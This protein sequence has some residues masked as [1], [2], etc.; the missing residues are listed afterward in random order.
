LEKKELQ[1]EKT[2]EKKEA[3]LVMRLIA[4]DFKNYQN[5]LCVFEGG[6]KQGDVDCLAKTQVSAKSKG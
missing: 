1:K 4:P 3:F 6:C 5:F 2:L